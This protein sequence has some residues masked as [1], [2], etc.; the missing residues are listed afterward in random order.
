MH[1][2]LRYISNATR[3]MDAA[4]QSPVY[5]ITGEGLKI[6]AP[7]VQGNELA[8]L[9]YTSEIWFLAICFIS[10]HKLPRGYSSFT[11]LPH[12]ALERP[13]SEVVA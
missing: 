6:K 2:V 3:Q 7:T 8:A 4:Y 13:A 10:P 11:V 12:V 5:L 1:N 9:E